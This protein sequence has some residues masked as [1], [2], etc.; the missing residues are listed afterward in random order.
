M[1]STNPY[2]SVVN[3]KLRNI[4]KK[5]ERITSLEQQQQQLPNKPLN[6]EQVMLTLNLIVHLS[7]T[8]FSRPD[9]TVDGVSEFKALCGGSFE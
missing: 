9:C 7:L 1:D 5:L 6:G 3:K 2:V 8:S 4:K